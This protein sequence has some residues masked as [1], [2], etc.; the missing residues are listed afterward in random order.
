M[1]Q[2]GF[3]A[4]LAGMMDGLQD[5]LAGRVR[6]CLHAALDLLILQRGIAED[7]LHVA[8]LE[9]VQL[10]S[11]P[12][13]EAGLGTMA[14]MKLRAS[15][16][17]GGEQGGAFGGA[18]S[19]ERGEAGRI[20]LGRIKTVLLNV[21][22]DPRR[23]LAADAE[24]VGQFP[25]V[26]SVLFAQPVQVRAEFVRQQSGLALLGATPH[27][28][29]SRQFPVLTQLPNDGGDFRPGR[30]LQVAQAAHGG[31]T[32]AQRQQMLLGVAGP[33]AQHPELSQRLGVAALEE[34]LAFGL[35]PEDLRLDDVLTDCFAQLSQ[36]RQG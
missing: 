14:A 33:G 4:L 11:Q 26:D 35:A 21:L 10:A 18:G 25:T 12:Q 2:Q 34:A 16:P 8:R 9:T 7:R 27:T 6:Q 1:S 32:H 20:R 13:I 28:F 15:F 24:Q 36:E 3:H 17:P 30:Q 23:L 22:D 19:Q 5:A 31:G 29:E